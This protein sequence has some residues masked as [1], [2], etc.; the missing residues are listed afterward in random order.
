MY[1]S[2]SSE[3]SSH[4]ASREIPRLLRNPRVHCRVHKDPPLVPILSQMYPAHKFPPY[5][6][7]IH[8]NVILPTTLMSSAWFLPFWFS[9]KKYFMHF[10]SLPCMLHVPHIV[11]SLIS[12]S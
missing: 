10:S 12:S 2:P 4:S 1:H 5:F 9:N 7:K 8:F 6:P 3:A 11:T